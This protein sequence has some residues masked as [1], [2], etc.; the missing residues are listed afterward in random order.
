MSK[1][2]ALIEL[3]EPVAERLGYELIALEFD[4]GEYAT[5]RLFIDAEAGVGLEDCE[6]MS[7]QVGALLD[8]ED[9]IAGKYA[10]EVSSPGMDRPLTKLEH[11]KRFLGQKARVKLRM[12]DELGRRNYTGHIREVSDSLVTLEVD[13]ELCDLEFNNIDKARI[14]PEF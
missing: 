5:L 14:V 7:R 3:I 10:L 4:S 8:V 13:N 11:F 6:R 2:Q 1:N 12:V 9:P